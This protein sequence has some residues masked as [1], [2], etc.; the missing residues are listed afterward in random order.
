MP[1]PPQLWHK[2]ITPGKVMQHHRK[3][4]VLFGGQ[5]LPSPKIRA[6]PFVENLGFL[7]KIARCQYYREV[8]IPQL[9]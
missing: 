4:E 5:A 7:M 8:P 6:L 1:L 2:A 9:R 3:A